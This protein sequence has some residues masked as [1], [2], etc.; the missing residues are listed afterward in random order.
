MK[1]KVMVI[2]V[3]KITSELLLKI[4]LNLIRENNLAKLDTHFYFLF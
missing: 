3:D 1:V 4:F 2:N